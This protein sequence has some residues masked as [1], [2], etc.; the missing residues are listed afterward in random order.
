[1]IAEILKPTKKEKEKVKSYKK[2]SKE[3]IAIF[4]DYRD[5]QLQIEQEKRESECKSGKEVLS[6]TDSDQERGFQ[7]AD[8]FNRRLDEAAGLTA[9]EPDATV[10][11]PDTTQR[12]DA[13]VHFDQEQGQEARPVGTGEQVQTETNSQVDSSEDTASGDDELEIL[14]QELVMRDYQE[15]VLK[16][17]LAIKE[18]EL[19]EVDLRYRQFSHKLDKE[20]RE[21]LKL[22]G[23]LKKRPSASANPDPNG[24]TA[25]PS[26]ARDTGT[27]SRFSLVGSKEQI[28]Q[29]RADRELRKS[30]LQPDL[31][32]DF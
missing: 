14:K 9:D 24:R 5:S 11:L 13:R 15:K 20:E 8:E 32:Y 23:E 2:N 16:E 27:I 29:A 12:K 1:M 4:G 18:R 30:R 26:L 17:Q 19:A 22:S 31:S 25:L 10:R 3:L 21:N 28:E 7:T 6:D